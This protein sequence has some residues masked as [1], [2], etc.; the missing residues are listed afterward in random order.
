MSPLLFNLL[1]PSIADDDLEHNIV[2]NK[3]TREATIKSK[4]QY[5]EQN[6]LF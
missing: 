3:C 6:V 2:E 5:N 4:G 1:N